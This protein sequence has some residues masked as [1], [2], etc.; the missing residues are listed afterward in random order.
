[1]TRQQLQRALAGLEVGADLV[2]QLGPALNSGRAI[3]LHGIPGTGKTS[4][5]QRLARVLPDLVLVPYAIAVGDSIIEVFDPLLHV[6]VSL[7]APAAPLMIQSGWD[8]RFACCER[9]VVM[10]GAELTIDMLEVQR[11]VVARTCT[12]PLQLKANNGVLLID[13]LGRQRVPPRSIFDRWIVPMEERRDYL[14]AG[15]GQH[16]A[17]PFDQVLIFSTNVAPRELA[18]DA[19]LRR[20]GYKIEFRAADE[21]QYSEIWKSVCKDRGMYYDPGVLAYVVYELYGKR[22]MPLLPCHPRDLIGMALDLKAYRGESL[23]IDEASITWAWN[24]Y[25]LDSGPAAASGK[26]VSQGG[27]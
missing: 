11:D 24:N 15:S 3:F 21:Q 7:N 26:S 27:N 17:V 20:I 23:E 1:V 16:F 9:P 25:F 12:A 5:A 13:D 6:E 19:F 22:G 8:T 2:D 4:V 10:A 18:D 14:S